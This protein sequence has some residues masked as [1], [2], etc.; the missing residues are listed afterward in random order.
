MNEIF[1]RRA[2]IAI[3]MKVPSLLSS[4]PSDEDDIDGSPT[5]KK[6]A[7]GSVLI[8]TRNPSRSCMT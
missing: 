4:F 1:H 5:L 7:Y 8:Y 3:L 2:H 6:P